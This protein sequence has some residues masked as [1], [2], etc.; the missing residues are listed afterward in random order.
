MGLDIAGVYHQPLE[1]RVIN[2]RLQQSGPHAPVPPAAEAAVG[3]LPISVVRG[4]ISPRSAGAQYPAHGVDKPPV[5]PVSW[6]GAGSGPVGPSPPGKCG[7]NRSQTASVI[8]WRRCATV[9]PPPSTLSPFPAIYHP[10]AILT[11]PPRALPN[12]FSQAA[13]G[14]DDGLALG[15]VDKSTPVPD[16]GYRNPKNA[17]TDISRGSTNTPTPGADAPVPIDEVRDETARSC[18]RQ[19][20]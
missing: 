13:H 19:N 17:I 12:W 5:V 15:C 8:S 3:V 14:G 1:I 10:T 4:Q 20:H 2:H 18:Q 9:I 7:L 16:Y 11:T 6:H